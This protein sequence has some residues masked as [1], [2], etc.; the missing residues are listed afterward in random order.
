MIYCLLKKETETF[1]VLVKSWAKTSEVQKTFYSI[2]N[3]TKRKQSKNKETVLGTLQPC[4]KTRRERPAA[5][6]KQLKELW[7]GATIRWA[8]LFMILFFQMSYLTDSLK[9][10]S[11]RCRIL[12]HC[13][14]FRKLKDFK[15]EKYGNQTLCGSVVTVV[16]KHS[17]H[18]WSPACTTCTTAPAAGPYAGRNG[19]HAPGAGGGSPG[20]AWQACWVEDPQC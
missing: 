3:R 20:A 11:E 9:W 6:T 13:R 12:A 5:E 14:F 16:L 7:Q 19:C 2:L 4:C 10:S 18:V 17:W 8:K 15:C 1:S